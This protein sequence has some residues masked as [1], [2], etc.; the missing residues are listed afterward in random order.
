MGLELQQ[1]T[2]TSTAGSGPLQTCAAETRAGTTTLTF[3]LTVWTNDVIIYTYTNNKGVHKCV[4][5]M[6]EWVCS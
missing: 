3:W 5:I 2:R 4:E 1:T 6:W